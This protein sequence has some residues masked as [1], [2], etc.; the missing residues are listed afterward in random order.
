ML[1]RPPRATRMETL[2]PYTTRFRAMQIHSAK[3]NVDKSDVNFEELARSTDDFNGA[4]LQV[5]KIGRAHVCTPVTNAHLVCR[6]LLA[7]KNHNRKAN[8]NTYYSDA[9]P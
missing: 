9:N 2:L 4:Q 7:Q 1:R 8:S 5:R 3:M 6:L